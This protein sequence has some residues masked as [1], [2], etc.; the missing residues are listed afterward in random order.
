MGEH[1]G[2]KEERVTGGEANIQSGKFPKL[3]SSTDI[4]RTE[5]GND[6]Y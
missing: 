3:S 5:K 4:V 2:T 1:C 6:I